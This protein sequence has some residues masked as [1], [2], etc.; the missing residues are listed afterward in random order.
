MQT[1]YP[2]ITS[3]NDLQETMMM[4]GVI[5][6]KRCSSNLVC[7][8]SQVC[9]ILKSITLPPLP[10]PTL[11][12]RKGFNPLPFAWRLRNLSQILSTTR[13]R[14]FLAKPREKVICC[15]LPH[16]TFG[17]IALVLT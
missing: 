14:F 5:V 15:K 16:L 11:P 1:T 12:Q 3:T 2:F 17:C 13:K 8:K 4:L 9:G 6:T 10:H 7:N